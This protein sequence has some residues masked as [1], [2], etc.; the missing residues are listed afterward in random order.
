MKTKTEHIK[1]KIEE[2][3]YVETIEKAYMFSSKTLLDLLVIE[4]DLM[5]R[6]RSVKHY[7]LLDKGDFVLQF[8]NLCEKELSKNVDHVLL[9]RLESFLEIAM[10]MSSANSDPYKEDMRTILMNDDLQSQMFKILSIQTEEEQGNHILTHT[11]FCKA[12]LSILEYKSDVDKR[13]LTGFESF[14]F[15]YKVQWPIS[16]IL[17]HR[18]VACYQMIF[19]HLF[20]CKYVERML[21]QIWRSHKIAK[22][23]SFSSSFQYRAA[24]ALRQRMLHCVQ[25]L[26]YHMMVEI[27]EPNWNI[28]QQ[29]ISKV[30]FFIY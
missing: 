3:E 9:A 20:Y 19:R 11:L 16:L 28:F 17:N 2:R 27:I 30:S 18:A 22:K 13:Q 1:Y 21:G 26:E 4:H 24:F 15:G 7:F 29:R 25:N 6:L 12:N 8:L 23:Y 10:R 5:G 14:T